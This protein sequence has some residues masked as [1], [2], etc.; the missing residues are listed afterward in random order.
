MKKQFFGT[1]VARIFLILYAVIVIVPF[2][3][4]FLTST[5]SNAEFYKNIWAFSGDPIG[6]SIAN[7]AKAYEDGNIGRS[8]LNTVFICGV[9]VVLTLTL[10]AM[11][12]YAITRRRLKRAESL[13]FLY[14][15]GLLIPGLV[16]LTPMFLLARVLNL[17]DTRFIMILSYGTGTI[18]FCVFVMTAFFKT[19]PKD[20]ED[21]ASIDGANPWQIFG[22]IILPTVK[23]ALITAGIFCFLDYWSDYMRGL[24]FLISPEKHTISMGMLRFRTISGFK[25]D[26]GVTMAACVLFI[27]PVLIVYAIFQRQL[28]SGLTEGSVKG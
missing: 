3:M 26:W 16:G 5:K 13:N 9:A 6:N 2:A 24:L 4:L 15:I 11:V 12:S 27:L 14:L 10:S 22:I 1:I 25:I 7:Y 19:I 17:L 23:P 8:F 18:P 21:S 28:I 20:L